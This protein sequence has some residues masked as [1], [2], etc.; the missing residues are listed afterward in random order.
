MQYDM[1]M[2]PG[3]GDGDGTWKWTCR[4]HMDLYHGHENEAWTW[5]CSLDMDIQLGH[6]PAV[7]KRYAAWTDGHGHA[8]QTRTHVLDMDM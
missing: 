5:T 4:L 7:Y 2:Q 3:Y 6:G 8:A 1:D